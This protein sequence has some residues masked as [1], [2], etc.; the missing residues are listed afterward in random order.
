MTILS[1]LLE[2]KVVAILRGADPKDVLPIA[3]A[4]Y[5]GGIRC[6]EVTLNS[7]DALKV[8]KE[9]CS[10][11]KDKM[12]VGAGTV[13]DA[14][15]AQQALDAGAQFIIA[16]SVDI[17]TIKLTKQK[18]F[19]SIPGAFTATE[20]VTAY[21][22]GADIIKVFPAPNP[23]YIKDLMGPLSHIPMMPTGG[24]TMENILEFKKAGGVA[25]GIGS[26][27]VDTRQLITDTYLDEISVRA[28]RMITAVI[29]S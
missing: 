3:L 19:V 28:K 15:A 1:Q 18:G 20:I 16:P 29:N 10:V 5:E 22:A 23:K 13:L 4:L 17:E 11:V 26:A 12:L 25:F 7:A 8:I 2:H 6:I 24:I 9:T 27:L 14:T 21:K